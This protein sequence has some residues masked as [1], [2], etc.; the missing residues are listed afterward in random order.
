MSTGLEPKALKTNFCKRDE[1]I[2]TKLS[3]DQENKSMISSMLGLE[4]KNTQEENYQMVPIRISSRKAD[5]IRLRKSKEMS[6]YMLLSIVLLFILTHSFRLAFRIY[7]FL[8][9]NGNTS[10]NFDRCYEMGR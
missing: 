10:E 2:E 1:S 5:S 7:E 8:M 3:D 9:P 4:P 6:C